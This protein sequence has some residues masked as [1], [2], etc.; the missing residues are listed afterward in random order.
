MLSRNSHATEFE[1][2]SEDFEAKIYRVAISQ[3]ESF[4]TQLK[5]EQH[6]DI[7]ISST[8]RTIEKGEKVTKGRLKRVRNQLR[9]ESIY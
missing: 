5:K 4:N 8:R 6:A 7:L 1:F 9:I 2:E 3:N